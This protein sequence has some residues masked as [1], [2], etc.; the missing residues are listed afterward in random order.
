MTMEFESS[1]KRSPSERRP[2]AD[3]TRP[4]GARRHAVDMRVQTCPVCGGEAVASFPIDD[5]DGAVPARLQCPTCDP[6]PPGPR[7][8]ALLQEPAPA[9]LYAQCPGCNGYFLVV[10]WGVG[11]RSTYASCDCV[12]GR[13]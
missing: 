12:T 9:T 13:H 2:T 1:S 4:D 5:V 3:R 10:E 11:V 7:G 6:S 8:M